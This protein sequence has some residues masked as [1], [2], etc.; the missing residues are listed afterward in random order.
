M[1]LRVNERIHNEE[2]DEGN[3]L[4]D[5][6]ISWHPLQWME[7]T[8][9][10]K[11]IQ[12][13]WLMNLLMA[14]LTVGEPAGFL[15]DDD[16]ELRLIAGSPVEIA[17]EWGIKE[18]QWRKVVEDFFV[19]SDQY[20]GL[21]YNPVML[22]LLK[23]KSRLSLMARRNVSRRWNKRKRASKTVHK[24]TAHKPFR[25]RKIKENAHKPL[26]IKEINTMVSKSSEIKEIADPTELNIRKERGLDTGVSKS[27]IRAY[28]NPLDITDSSIFPSPA[29]QAQLGKKKEEEENEER[30]EKEERPKEGKEKKEGKEEED[31]KNSHVFKDLSEKEKKDQD[32]SKE[33]GD[34]ILVLTELKLS[35][36]PRLK[37]GPQKQLMTRFDETKF[38]LTKHMTAH[39][40]KKYPE[41]S[42]GDL[43]FLTEKFCNTHQGNAYSSWSK[44]F[45]NFVENQL[46]KYNYIPGSYD[47]RKKSNGKNGQRFESSTERRAREYRE[48]DERIRQEGE[49]LK[50]EAEEIRLQIEREKASREDPPPISL[51]TDGD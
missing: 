25:M 21:I 17:D 38:K 48:Y 50:R 22:D 2:E 23:D 32:P 4:R 11:A 33:E 6:E 43:D 20:P 19:Q 9:G 47:W 51:T 45:Y 15:P 12:V 31:K 16:E 1:I 44:A 18:H 14:S 34:E 46:V 39:L 8:E 7:M 26:K 37:S 28:I 5:T 10:L 27:A 29:N 40:L 41:F 42:N 35:Q 3:V 49:E 13:G 36:A 30:K 24:K